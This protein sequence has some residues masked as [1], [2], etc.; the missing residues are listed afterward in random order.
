MIEELLNEIHSP[1]DIGSITSEIVVPGMPDFSLS[2]NAPAGKDLF[3]AKSRKAWDKSE[4]ARCDFQYHLRLTRRAST[5]FITIWQKSVFGRTLTDIKSDDSMVPFFIEN[6]V[7]VIHEM[8]GFHL[9][10]GSWALVTTPMRRH[11][12]RNFASRIAEGLAAELGIP[13][14]FD[15]AHCRSKQRIGAVF[16]ANNIPHEGNVIVFDDFVTTGSTLQ[17]MKNLLLKEGKN[18]IF[19]CGI[20]NKL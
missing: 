10:N 20:N 8:I 5:N 7:P 12:E 4:E 16:D 9:G 2:E 3:S 18:P 15:C 19:I 14:Y 1:E 13:F 11:K 6:L 17:S